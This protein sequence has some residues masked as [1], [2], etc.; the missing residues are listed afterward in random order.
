MYWHSELSVLSLHQVFEVVF[1]SAH[2]EKSNTY[3]MYK[4]LSQ[5]NWSILKTSLNDKWGKLLAIAFGVLLI[6]SITFEYSTCGALIAFSCKRQIVNLKI[7]K[8][9]NPSLNCIGMEG[10]LL[11]LVF[12]VT[13][14][15]VG[16]YL[17]YIDKTNFWEQLDHLNL[18]HM[19]LAQQGSVLEQWDR[20]LIHHW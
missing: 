13:W 6:C 9:L 15:R 16:S 18:N 14:Q 8:I 5:N 20:L 7:W 17:H 11:L 19:F 12:F 10:K 3:K 2:C 4:K 1:L